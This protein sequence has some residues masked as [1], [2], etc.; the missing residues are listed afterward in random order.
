MGAVVELVIDVL[1]QLFFGSI[2]ERRAWRWTVF[3]LYAALFVLAV[4]AAVLALI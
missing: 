1:G 3:A 4:G 2:S